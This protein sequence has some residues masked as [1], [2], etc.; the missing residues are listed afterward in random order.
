MIRFLV[1][2]VPSV[3]FVLFA[4]SII[5]FALPRLAPGDIAVTLAGTDPTAANVA[6]IREQLGLNRSPIVQYWD[7]ISGVLHGDLGQSYRFHRSVASLIGDRLESTLELALFATLLVVLIGTTLGVLAG[8]AK[9]RWAR[10]SFDLGNSFM[11]AIPSFLTALA[12]ILIFGVYHRWLPVSG[13]VSVAQDPAIGIQ[14]LVLPA[15]ALAIPPSAIVARLLQTEMAKVRNEDYVDLALAK[16][17]SPKRI[18]LRHVLRNSF[19]TAVVSIGLEIGTLLAGAVVIEAIFNRNGL[20][21]LAVSSVSTRDFT[22]L[23]V[24]ILG[25]VCIAVICQIVTEII[26]AALDPRIRLGD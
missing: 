4:S 2:K 7:W 25:V 11:I 13:E 20:G 15:V 18:T 12:L 22:V 10:T 3:A 19:G 1:R 8:S 9:R 17:A 23:Q 16:G 26:L 21:Q 5:A 14:Y 6:A 24:L